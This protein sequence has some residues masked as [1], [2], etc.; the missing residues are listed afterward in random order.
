[1]LQRTSIDNTAATPIGMDWQTMPIQ[2]AVVFFRS[3]CGSHPSSAI[4]ADYSK[5]RNL[6]ELGRIENKGGKRFT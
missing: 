5:E 1:M 4:A 2:A 6:D 3:I